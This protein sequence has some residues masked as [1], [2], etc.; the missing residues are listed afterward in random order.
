M[1]DEARQK[2]ANDVEASTIIDNDNNFK[3]DNAELGEARLSTLPI[4]AK[5]LKDGVL[6]R[7][8]VPLLTSRFG[9]LDTNDKQTTQEEHEQDD[10]L[11]GNE[12]LVVY[13]ALIIWYIHDDLPQS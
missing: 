7:R 5:N 8:L 6:N 11:V 2:I 10:M 9:N 12:E 13:D 4:A 3:R 1:I